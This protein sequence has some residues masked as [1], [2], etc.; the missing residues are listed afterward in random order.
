MMPSYRLFLWLFA[1]LVFGAL[2]GCYPGYRMD[3]E[4]GNVVTPGQRAQLQLG[5]D[6]REAQFI[7]GSPLIKD[8]FHANRWDYVYTLR[9]GATGIVDQ[10][11]LSLFFEN[12]LLID[13]RYESNGITAEKVNSKTPEKAADSGFLQRLWNRFRATD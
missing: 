7:L 9:D 13:I 5:M 1:V 8:P 6:Q 10:Q 11:R 3:V 2:S 12:D 4:Q